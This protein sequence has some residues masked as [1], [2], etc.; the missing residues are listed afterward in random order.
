MIIASAFAPEDYV[1]RMFEQMVREAPRY[2]WPLLDWF[3]QNYIGQ[4]NRF[5]SGRIPPFP[6]K[7]WSTYQRTLQ[8]RDRMNNFAEAP[9][10]RLRSELGVDH[11]TIWRLIDGLRTVQAGRDQHFESFVRGDEPPRKT[12]RYLLADERI[13]RTV[14]CFDAD[15]NFSAQFHVKLTFENKEPKCNLSILSGYVNNQVGQPTLSGRRH[16]IAL[17]PALKS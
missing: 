5:G 14:G 15:S 9:H 2:L 12:Q 11:P 6:P 10:R 3:E 8:G 17:I 16:D 4:Q 13:R 1:D 7:V